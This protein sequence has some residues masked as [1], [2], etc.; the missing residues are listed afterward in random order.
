M[1]CVLRRGAFS[2]EKF[3]M[4]IQFDLGVRENKINAT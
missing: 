3:K 1:E 2:K 4:Y